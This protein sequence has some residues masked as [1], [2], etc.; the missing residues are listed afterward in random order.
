MDLMA[1]GA[2]GQWIS[3][4]GRDADKALPF[5]SR[6]R[7]AGTAG[8]DVLDQGVSRMPGSVNACFGFYFPPPQMVVVVLQ[9]TQDCKARAVVVVDARQSWF[10]LLAAV[11][12][13]SVPIAAKG[14]GTFFRM[15]HQKEEVPFVFRQWG[16]RTIDADFRQDWTH[17]DEP[18]L[19]G[20]QGGTPLHGID[21]RQTGI[22]HPT[23][24][25][26]LPPPHVHLC[27]AIGH[28]LRPI[29]T[30]LPV[31]QCLL[32]SLCAGQ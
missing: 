12:V 28:L 3:G 10:P 23:S 26:S 16:M 21:L 20:T 2:S 8:V 27:Q 1:I 31:V 5:Y 32:S 4:V 15:H 7:T 18:G 6:Y 24:L 25:V 22:A 11:T 29:C 14:T 9:Y 13:R 19:T 17:D 30:I